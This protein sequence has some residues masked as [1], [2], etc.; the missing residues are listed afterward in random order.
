[1]HLL[2][3]KGL[4][5]SFSPLTLSFGCQVDLVPCAGPGMEVEQES[6][7]TLASWGHTHIQISAEMGPGSCDLTHV[8]WR[9]Q[10]GLPGGSGI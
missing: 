3:C 10:G 9:G 2:I 4:P 8:T 6:A 5:R 7:Q 1:M